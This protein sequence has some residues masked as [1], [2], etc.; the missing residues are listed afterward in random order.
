ML[1]NIPITYPSGEIAFQ[2]RL[3]APVT[4]MMMERV[5]VFF[6]FN[7]GIWVGAESCQVFPVLHT[8]LSKSSLENTERGLMLIAICLSFENLKQHLLDFPHESLAHDTARPPERK[9]CREY[10][11]TKQQVDK[12][13][14]RVWVWITAHTPDVQ[15]P[16]EQEGSLH[17]KSFCHQSSF[18]QLI[19]FSHVP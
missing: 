18:T 16:L 11:P 8:P 7:A 15:K 5:S 13:P 10:S 4:G 1:E 3:S 17:L 14:C 19:P 2:G 9:L 6:I 12:W